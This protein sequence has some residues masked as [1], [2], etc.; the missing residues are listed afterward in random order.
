TALLFAPTLD[1]VEAIY[2]W[3][4]QRF[5]SSTLVI[6]LLHISFS[7]MLLLPPAIFMGGT[8]PIMCRFFARRKSGGQIG[9]LYALNTLGATLG[10]FSAGYLLIPSLGLTYT[11][12][13]A[14]FGNL[15]VAAISWF[16]ASFYGATDAEGIKIVKP[17]KRFLEPAKHRPVLIAIGL[18]GFFSLAY[19]ILWTRVLL[20]FLGNTSYAFALMLSTFL[21]GIAI[22]GALYARLARPE[23][24]EK[25]IFILLTT[26]MG[27]V[28]LLTTPF[29]DQL[30]YLFQEAHKFGGENF[31]LVSLM[32]YLIVFA[33]IGL[34]TVL[35]GALLPAAVAMID[36]GKNHTGEGVGLV[37]LHN[38]IG[39][40]IGS[41]VAGFTLV[42]SFGLLQSFRGLAICNLVVAAVLAYLHCRQEH[43][44]R[45]VYAVLTVGF[46]VALIPVSWNQHLMN[47]GVYCYASKYSSMGGL[48]RVLDYENILEVFEGTETTVAVHE[49]KQGRFRFFTVNGKT[50]GGTGS[51]MATQ[52][53]IGQ[54]PLMIHPK[55]S[56]V[57]VI[58]LGTGITL[59]SMT[60]HPTQNIDCVEISPEVVE[61]E[62]YF[63]EANG[64]ALQDPKINLFVRD[65]RNLLL[66]SPKQYDVIISE[67]SNPWQTGNANLFTDEFYQLVNSRLKDG[68]IFC[69]WIGMY[70]ITLD[71]LKVAS[72]TL[73]KNFQ[74]M[75]IFENGPDLII[76]ASKTERSIDYEQLTQRMSHPK[77]KSLFSSIGIQSPGHLIAEA[78]VFTEKS[79]MT[80][81]QGVSTLNTDDHPVLEF[82]AHHILGEH[83]LGKLLA[84]N[85]QALNAAA[86][87][88]IYLPLDNLGDTNPEVADALRDIGYGYSLKGRNDIARH[89]MAKA[90]SF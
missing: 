70:D 85:L 84:T 65:G 4:A 78:Y 46:V 11:G 30:A 47:S 68:G 2:V 82:S 44:C 38:T 41:L 25:R 32:A 23:M 7:A 76:L 12:L 57:L 8:F 48:D 75:T 64:H 79:L 10:C 87:E 1:V 45:V 39:G 63:R 19:E 54:L 40:V 88:T 21:V 35:S 34:P 69:Q 56:D 49:D 6:P 72:R 13:L 20:L 15:A 52:V 29:Y 62:K 43:S 90:A 58:G 14:V 26:G 83:S 22:G 36:P 16:L 66:T 59:H 86:D 55:P 67:P 3:L 77:I 37:V 28:I 9:R 60:A 53:L 51:D 5:S 81:S 73:L 24:N 80:F 33:I 42:P 27:L 61:A 50:D 18:V 31:W 89:F 17:Q 71:N 74:H